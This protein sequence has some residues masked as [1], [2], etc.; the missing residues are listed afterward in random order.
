MR[1]RLETRWL[2][3]GIIWLAALALT[4]WNTLQID[5]VAAV[6]DQN[7]QIRQEVSFQRH[8][9]TKLAQV[10]RA[11]D[12]LTLAAESVDLA[13]VVARSRLGALAAAFELGELEM[14]AELHQVTGT[15]GQ[16]P[17]NLS[18]K[19][20]VDNAMGF[21]TALRNYPYFVLRRTKIKD[22][23]D[24]AGIDMEIV[25]DLRYRIEAAGDDSNPAPQEITR[26]GQSKA[27]SL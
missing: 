5:A 18:L 24:A 19:G 12:A 14:R 10:L 25:I 17:Y 2:I 27:E 7:E 21:L 11:R 13:V 15:E 16:V 23:A 4:Y 1:S 9:A 8:N 26:W 22:A 3:V 20:P 6:R